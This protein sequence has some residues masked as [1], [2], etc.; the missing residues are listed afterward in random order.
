M[1]IW[2]NYAETKPPAGRV[3]WKL[4]HVSIAGLFVVFD[5]NMQLR[6][7]G[8]KNVLSPEFGRWNGNKVLLPNGVQWQESACPLGASIGVLIAPCRV[9]GKA[10]ALVGSTVYSRGGVLVNSHPHEWNDWTLERCCNW[11][12]T[13]SFEDPR[14]LVSKWNQIHGVAALEAEEGR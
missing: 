5:A 6:G 10:P 12:S 9:C 11:S 4:P 2:N 1:S 3:R 7:A 8:H 14:E 13:P